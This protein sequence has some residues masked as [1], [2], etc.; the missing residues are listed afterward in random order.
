V[1]A[2]PNITTGS[3][4]PPHFNEFSIEIML[5]SAQRV[6]ASENHR[7]TAG[8]IEQRPAGFLEVS[9][10]MHG[11]RVMAHRES[12]TSSTDAKGSGIGADNA[13]GR[14]RQATCLAAPDV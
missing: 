10:T 14:Q 2:L 7:S 5:N 13:A 6:K 9:T 11:T 8:R 1:A 12:E 4:H 3:T